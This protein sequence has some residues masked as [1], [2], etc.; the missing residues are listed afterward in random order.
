MTIDVT[1][2]SDSERQAVNNYVHSLNAKSPVFPSS[3]LNPSEPVGADDEFGTIVHNNAIVT[4]SRYETETTSSQEEYNY[5]LASYSNSAEHKDRTLVD[6]HY[7]DL[8]GPDGSRTYR[9]T[10]AENK[11]N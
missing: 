10:D 1:K 3:V 6:Q 7:L 4:T 11:N 9:D 5:W 2:L 8:P